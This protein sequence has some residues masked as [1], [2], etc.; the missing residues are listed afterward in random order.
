MAAALKKKKPRKTI[1][2]NKA[3]YLS[4]AEDP[5]VSLKVNR[6]KKNKK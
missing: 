5:L 4:R 1:S 3:K 2:R 6:L